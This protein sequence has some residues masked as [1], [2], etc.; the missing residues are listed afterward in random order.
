MMVPNNHVLYPSS[1]YEDLPS[2]SSSPVTAVK[3]LNHSLTH[4][5][6]DFLYDHNLSSICI[7]VQAVISTLR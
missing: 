4:L 3:R 1:E 5:T 6:C 2:S 7:Q